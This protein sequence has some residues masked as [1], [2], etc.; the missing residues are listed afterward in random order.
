MDKD[1]ILATIFDLAIRKYLKIEE[2][3]K[4]K[5]LMPDELDY[6]L[7]KLKDFGD[8]NE[9]ERK[10]V[11]H[12]FKDGDSVKLKDFKLNF[13][14]FHNLEVKNFSLLIKKG[15]Y[16]EN[17]KGTRGMLLTFGILAIISLNLLLG[18][19]LIYLS[20]KF[21]GRTQLGDKIDWQIDGLKIFLKS[22]SRHHGWQAKNLI[23]VE[24]YIPYA[25]ALGLH[26]EFMDQL[27]IINPNYNPSWYSGGGSFY[28]GY[29][30][31]YSSMSSSVTTSASS[32]SSGFSGGSSGGGGGGGGGGSW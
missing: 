26:D 27:K 22:M 17:P 28:H 20:R 8:L 6:K 3:K 1:D 23:T 9:F 7:I 16:K 30:G 19:V 15:L 10:L 32:S 13:L 24:K 25:I 31:M 5:T 4:V 29:S 21:T 2:V 18:L 14:D 11:E 12:I